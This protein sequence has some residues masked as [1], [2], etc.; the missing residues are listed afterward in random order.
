MGELF[1]FRRSDRPLSPLKDLVYV[2]ELA[3]FEPS[4]LTNLKGLENLEAIGDP[5]QSC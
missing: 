3:Q 5:P 2:K 4:V 1:Y